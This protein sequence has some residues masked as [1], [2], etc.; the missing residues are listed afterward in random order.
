MEIRRNLAMVILL[1]MS[2]L[3]YSQNNQYILSGYI[4]DGDGASLPGANIALANDSAVTVMRT[5]TDAEGYFSFQKVPAGNYHITIIYLGFEDYSKDIHIS[6][7]VSLGKIELQESSN[8]LDEVTIMGRYTDIKPSGETVIRLAGNPL[9]KGQSFINFMRNVRNLDVTDK[10]IKVQGRDNTRFYVD[11]KEVSFEQLKALSPSMIARVEIVPHADASYGVNATGGVV[12]VYLREEGGMLG[13]LSFYGQADKYGY[14]DGTPSVNIL[15]SKG[16]FTVSN[17][18]R[19]T[20]YSHYVSKNDQNN[21]EG[22]GHTVTDVLNKDRAFTDNLSLRYA[23]NKTDRI[24]VYGSVFLLKESSV[25]NSITDTD[26]LQLDNNLRSHSYNAGIQLRKGFGKNGSYALLV[27]EY[28]KNKDNTDANYTYNGDVDPAN[29]RIN[30]DKFNIRPRLYWNFKDNMTLSAGLEFYYLIDRHKED[31]T[32][33][34]SYIADGN[35]NSSSRDYGAWVQYSA[36]LSDRLFIRAGLN[37][38]GTE[39]DYKNFLDQSSNVSIYEDGIYPTLFGQ[40]TFN[41]EKLHYIAIGLRHYYS[42]PNYN[43]SIPT[44]VWQSENLYSIGNPNL[45]KENYDDIEIFYSPNKAWSISYDFNYGNNMVNVIMH[46]DADRQGVFYTSPENTGN[47]QRHTLMV[48]YADKLTKFWY[49]NTK[50]YGVYVDEKVGQGGYDCALARFSS[51][52]D[53]SICDNLGLTLNLYA[54]TKSRN[55]SYI[56]NARYSVDVGARLS[57]F[58]GKA[59]VSLVWANMLYNRGRIKVEEPD[60]TYMR[61]D[62]SPDSRVQ[63]S[64]SWN[65]S[66]GRKIKR[67]NLPTVSG[68]YRETPTF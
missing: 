47:R 52:N 10:D 33:K 53:F 25:T 44:V 16:K 13:S 37:Y 7:N 55:A 11:D 54:T 42:L 24:D 21:G 43:Y 66:A 60:F 20:P 5:S 59:D 1:M 29:Q 56:S 49:T 27:S 14:V 18:L 67:E 68:G 31:G 35:Y 23:F 8:M 17:M 41:Q 63:L 30:T 62:L 51:Y 9:A 34:F 15:Y 48:G 4:V 39:T 58:E 19:G 40:W 3:C 2:V 32:Q 46:R 22:Q 6:S 57:L 28:S 61:R 38:H 26:N 45:R 12:K 50:V 65:F 64:V 36:Q